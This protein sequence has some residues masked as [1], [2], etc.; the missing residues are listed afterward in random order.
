VGTQKEKE[1]EALKQTLMET[2][3][4]NHRWIK[5][6]AKERNQW[7]PTEPMRPVDPWQVQLAPAAAWN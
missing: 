2:Q 3:V 4:E 1:Q 7:C 6:T 5:K